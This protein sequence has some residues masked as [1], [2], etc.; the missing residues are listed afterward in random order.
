MSFTRPS[1][2][3][4]QVGF[5]STFDNIDGSDEEESSQRPKRNRKQDNSRYVAPLESD[6]EDSDEEEPDEDDSE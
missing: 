6:E 5:V 4:Q 3:R 1:R 2:Q